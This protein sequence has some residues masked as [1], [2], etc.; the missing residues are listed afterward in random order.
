MCVGYEG[1]EHELGE[2]T[3]ESILT[4][5]PDTSKSQFSEM[6]YLEMNVQET[7]FFTAF[8]CFSHL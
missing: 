7:A 8:R 1:Q 4:F 2:E 3:L 6:N 5:Y